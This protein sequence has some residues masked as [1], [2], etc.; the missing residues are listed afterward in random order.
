MRAALL[1][2]SVSVLM[3]AGCPKG[4]SENAAKPPP[5]PAAKAAPPVAPAAPKAGT[6]T[7]AQA[8]PGANPARIATVGTRHMAN[9]PSSVTGAS[10]SVADTKEGVEVTV[11]AQAEAAVSEIRARAKHMAGVSAK[12]PP[13]KIEHDGAGEG[14]GGT[15]ACPLV[16]KDTKL[17]VTEIPGGAKIEVKADKPEQVAALQATAKARSDRL[18]TPK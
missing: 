13:A 4:E 9:C 2:G 16:I 6:A 7:G 11:T 10:T 8:A 12:E 18:A 5:S 3:L 15:G 1:V 14:G 17:T